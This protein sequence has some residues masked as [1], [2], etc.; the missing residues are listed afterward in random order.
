MRQPV[1][2]PDGSKVTKTVSTRLV[3]VLPHQE[4]SFGPLTTFMRAV[5][6]ILELL[7]TRQ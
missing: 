5:N 2:V 7:G 6:S 1:G 4:P 3:P